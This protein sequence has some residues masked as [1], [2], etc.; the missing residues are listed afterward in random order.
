MSSQLT[1]VYP[2]ASDSAPS[3]KS[4]E[5]QCADG[6]GEAGRGLPSAGQDERAQRHDGV[7]AAAALAHRERGHRGRRGQ[8]TPQRQKNTQRKTMVTAIEVS[9][10]LTA[11]PMAPV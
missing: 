10:G 9:G 5:Q 2:P 1:P 7:V 6:G 11:G 4:A 8:R 3:E